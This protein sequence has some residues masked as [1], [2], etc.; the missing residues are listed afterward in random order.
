MIRPANSLPDVPRSDDAV[1]ERLRANDPDA[2]DE[3]VV[4]Y[5]EA[6]LRAAVSYLGSRE[7][8]E[9]I[10][11]DVL[12]NVWRTRAELSAPAGLRLY[13]YAAVRNRA[14]SLLRHQQSERRLDQSAMLDASA[15]PFVRRAEPTDERV[16]VAELDVAIQ[17]A[18]ARLPARC[19]EAFMLSRQHDLTHAE[20]ARVMG[21]SIKTVQEQVGRAL[22]SLR[23]ALADW[24][25]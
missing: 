3:I 10:V 19:R 14:I 9:E 6:L 8:G 11:Q 7:S 4:T 1:L 22:K 23:A 12:L 17:H 5:Y 18:I 2:F 13:L 20:I 15:L 16:H 21:T 24:L 25:D